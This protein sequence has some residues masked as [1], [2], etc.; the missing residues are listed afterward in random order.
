MKKSIVVITKN[1]PV[2]F[3]QCV[4][5]IFRYTIPPYELVIVDNSNL[6]DE[7]QEKVLK[8][9]ESV[10][11]KNTVVDIIRVGKNIGS[12]A[13]RNMGFY[14]A[15]GDYITFMDDDSVIKSFYDEKT[16]LI[17]YFISAMQANVRIGAVGPC[18][19]VTPRLNFIALTTAMLTVPARIK[20]YGFRF[21]ERLGHNF[22]K[23][24]PTCGYED[25]DFSYSLY[26]CGYM[27]YSPSFHKQ[28]TLPFYH[29]MPK[30]HKDWE[31]RKKWADENTAKIFD[32][33]WKADLEYYA[34]LNEEKEEAQVA[35]EF[36]D[37]ISQHPNIDM[38]KSDVKPP[39]RIYPFTQE[40]LAIYNSDELKLNLGSGDRYIEGHNWCNVDLYAEKADLR[41]NVTNLEGIKDN[42]VAMILSTHIIEHFRLEELKVVFDEWYRVL[43]PGG[44]LILEFPDFLKCAR[45]FD[46][47]SNVIT[48]RLNVTPQILGCPFMPGHSHYA[49][50]DVDFVKFVLQHHKFCNVKENPSTPVWNIKHLVSRIDSQK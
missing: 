3:S 46:A 33:K 44:H 25:I 10:N 18:F 28:T 24:V 13:A 31:Q 32:E 27:L 40:Q 50:L 41:C 21:D 30:E 4:D 8:S 22:D 39:D 5:S 48:E 37:I 43:R 45:F 42:S 6:P 1:N 20:T 35:K 19:A 38:F 14:R 12:S 11:I 47:N 26:R 16:D 2:K 49:L 36:E 17:D 9:V 34:K 29:P 23:A 15:S 7:E